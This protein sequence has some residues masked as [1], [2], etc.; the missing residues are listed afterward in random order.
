VPEP[1]ATPLTPVPD[2]EP[3]TLSYTQVNDYRTCP[4]QYFYSHIAHVPLAA[5]P[6]QMY[7][8]AIHHAIRIWHLHRIKGLPIETADVI[9]ALEGACRARAS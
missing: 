9:A 7:G 6:S 5:D 1:P 3:L 2:S 8:M 4:L